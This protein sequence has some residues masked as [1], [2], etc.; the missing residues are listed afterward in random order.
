MPGGHSAPDV[1]LLLVFVQDGPGLG[2]KLGIAAPQPKGDI[3]VDGGFGD[4][5]VLRSRAHGGTGF[6]DVHSQFT[7][8]LLNLL[9]HFLTSDAVC[10]LSVFCFGGNYERWEC[11]ASE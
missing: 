11:R 3:L 6:N 5:E 10:C 4:A 1:A 8:S 2:V 7:G 9:C